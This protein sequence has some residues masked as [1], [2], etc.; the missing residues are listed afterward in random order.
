MDSIQLPKLS[1]S[2]SF[3]NDIYNLLYENNNFIYIISGIIAAVISGLAPLIF[4][5]LFGFI[6]DQIG[7]GIINDE[8]YK[9]INILCSYLFLLYR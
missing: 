3:I 9:N 2:S 8:I 5:I 1:S 7:N 4:S 6:V